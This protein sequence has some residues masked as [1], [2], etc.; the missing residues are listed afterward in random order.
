MD[1]WMTLTLIVAGLLALM[2]LRVPVAFAFLSVNIVAAIFL[3]GGERG[4]EQ[5]VKSI[6]DS[7]S[8]FTLAPI[9]FFILMG[10]LMFQTGIAPK[11][12]DTLD[13]WLGRI[14]GRLSLLSIGGGTL[15][16]TLTGSSMASTAMLGSTLVP[17]M[18]KRNY[19]RPMTIGPILSSGTL[20]V[21]IPPS[22]LGVL[23][24]SMG[25]ISVGAFMIAIIV[26]GILMALI[27]SLYIVIRVKMQ[28]ELAPHYDQGKVPFAEKVKATVTYIL[29]LGLIIFLVIGLIFLGIATPTEAAATGAF[30]SLLL[31]MLY[32]QLT[33]KNFIKSISET[34]KVSAMML[35]IVGGSAAFSQILSFSGASRNLVQ[36]VTHLDVSPTA[37]LLL[38]LLL[39]IVMGT[40]MES[41]S[42]LMI[43]LPIFIPIAQLLGFDLLW[44]AAILLITVELGTISPPF[45]VGLFVMKAVAPKGTTMGNIFAAV[46]P[47]LLLDLLLVA[48][49][50][51]VP[52]TVTWL[53]SLMRNS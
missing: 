28:P 5:L 19:K 30:G 43:T 7:L 12:I 24:A 27:F 18:E 48:I 13:K 9:V 10:E 23:L 45:G 6:D 20:A 4:L 1:W 31:A 49:I 33:W 39:V 42:I 22:G 32:K 46:I 40:F 41:V 52:E 53:P 14:P 36:M 3:W 26:P 50:M 15:L 8:S 47:F 51:I 16:S 11:L 2:F 44:F 35:L 25:K 17:E 37:V 34:M 38:M 21:M 29:P